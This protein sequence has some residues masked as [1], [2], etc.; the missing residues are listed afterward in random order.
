[1][2]KHIKYTKELLETLIKESI[3]LAQVLDKLYDCKYSG[4]TYA[5]IK[6]KIKQFN[7]DTSHFKGQSWSRGNRLKNRRLTPKDILCKKE[8]GTRTLAV[9]LRRS[10]IETGRLYVCEICGIDPIWNEQELR[11][12]ID[13]INNDWLDNQANN[14][15][16]CCPNCHSQ[17]RHRMNLGK[18]SVLNMA[19]DSKKRKLNFT[20]KCISCDTK[21][22]NKA[23][24][25]KICAIK[26]LRKTTKIDWPVTS[27]LIKMVQET[28]CSSV[29]RQLGVSD[30][31]VN[32][33]IKN[34]PVLKVSNL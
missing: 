10:L 20:K 22:S 23:T 2:G 13:H 32:K 9:R 1:M 30:T 33:R 26:R 6:K 12:E 25:C 11:L 21:I 5:F 24:R 8:S 31:A 4:S 18:T 29:A 19:F 17:Q 15:R 3:S 16:F 7:I 27:T 14:L 34:H 28:S